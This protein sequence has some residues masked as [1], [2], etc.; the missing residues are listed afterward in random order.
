MRSILLVVAGI[1]VGLFAGQLATELVNSEHDEQFGV[2]TK[3]VS[4]CQLKQSGCANGDSFG[5]LMSGTPFKLRGD[6]VIEVQ[7]RVSPGELR[8]ASE[9]YALEKGHSIQHRLLFE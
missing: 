4:L 7:L 5:G 8:R 2:M 3:D 1:V 9:L 6:L